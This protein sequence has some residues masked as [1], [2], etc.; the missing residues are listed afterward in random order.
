MHKPKNAESLVLLESFV[1]ATPSTVDVSTFSQKSHAQTKIPCSI[2]LL[3]CAARRQGGEIANPS[4]TGAEDTP[5]K[6]RTAANALRT[7]GYTC[8]PDAPA[9]LKQTTGVGASTVPVCTHCIHE[10]ICQLCA[11]LW[12]KSTVSQARQTTQDAKPT[13]LQ[14]R[15]M[16][17]VRCPHMHTMHRQKPLAA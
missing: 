8:N 2:G 7:R 12:A 9:V 15:R 5:A 6:R 10:C 17:T 11:L 14:L 1:Q 3:S 13:A 4:L 16:P